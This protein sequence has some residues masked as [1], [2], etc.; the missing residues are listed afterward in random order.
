MI[1]SILRISLSFCVVAFFCVS[2]KAQQFSVTSFRL[3]TNDISAYINP[4][5]DLNDEACA[6]IKVVG[7]ADFVFSTP[8]GIVQ[9]KEEVGEIWIYVPQGTVLLTIKHPQWGVLRDFM[10]QDPLE[11]RLTYELVL[12]VP[13]S[14]IEASKEIIYKRKDIRFWSRIPLLGRNMGQL[15]HL[16][17]KWNIPW[18]YLLMADVGIHK[19]GPLF[20]LR[21]GMLKKHGFYLSLGSNAFSMP[22]IVGECDE[23]GKVVGKEDAAYYTGEVKDG[24]WKVLVGGIHR[25]FSNFSL[26]EGI[27]YGESNVDW[28]TSNGDYLHNISYST[29]GVNA[30]LGGIYHIGNMVFQAGIIT[31]NAKQWEASFGVGIV[32]K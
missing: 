26:Y 12:N 23:K 24:R 14:I 18:S 15:P 1:N 19:N 22:P 30:E 11:S 31:I 7:N 4:V 21:L 16:L 3:L 29:Q 27:G 10:F 17:N 5:R 25:L 8:L 6:L 32:I 9:R 13:Q 20:G 2:L 28:E